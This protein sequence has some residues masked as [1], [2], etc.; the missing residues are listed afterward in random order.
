MG[1]QYVGDMLRL[2]QIL[3]NLLGNAMKYTPPGGVIRL[4]VSEKSENGRDVM[5]YF[6][7]EDNGIGI[8]HEQKEHIFDRFYRV[9]ASRTRKEHFGLGLS[10]AKEI[11][12]LHHGRITV[13]D[14]PGGGTT[15]TLILPLGT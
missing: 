12:S 2:N 9:D 6:E 7:V 15:F 3:M 5:L 11:V 1:D 8:P 14:T 13:E 10:I 4:S